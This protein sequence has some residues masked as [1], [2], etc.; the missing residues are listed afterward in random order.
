MFS[1]CS[2]DC[3]LYALVAILAGR[4][5]SAAWER[6]SPSATSESTATYMVSIAS[7]SRDSKGSEN[8]LVFRRLESS[9]S[10]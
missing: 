10:L 8:R 5:I 9:G 6:K 3:I 2:L 1:G 4:G 7:V